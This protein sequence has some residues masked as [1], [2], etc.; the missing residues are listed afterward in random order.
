ML[1]TAASLAMLSACSQEPSGGTVAPQGQWVSVFNGK[2]LDNWV[3]KIRGRTLGDDPSNT[4]RI[5]NGI[6]RV[7]YSDCA[8]FGSSNGMLVYRQPLTRYW[9]RVEY[10][11]VGEQPAGAPAWAFRDSGV[12]FHGQTPDSVAVD[13]EFPVGLEINL[14][15]GKLIGRSR[16]TGNVCTS[17]ATIEMDGARLAQKCSATSGTTIRMKDQWVRLEAKVD[18]DNIEHWING[19]SVA[20]YSK[21]QLDAA[22]PAAKA[23]L[24]A[25]ASPSLQSGYL[26]LQSNGAPIEFR[27]VEILPIS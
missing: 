7:D 9:L 22:D 12:Q 1:L 20:K 21:P 25:G 26:S 18:G 5:D 16:P 6:L 8:N 17:G 27:K 11:F 3:V 23:L 4:F 19:E 15:G 24:D 10:R 13:Q 14:I 2:D